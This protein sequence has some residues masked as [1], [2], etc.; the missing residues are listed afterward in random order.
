MVADPNQP[1][2][3]LHKSTDSGVCGTRQE[4]G[5]IELTTSSENFDDMDAF[6][7]ETEVKP[8]EAVHCY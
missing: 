3:S 2:V 8:A 4:E 6:S 1:A 5:L 7:V